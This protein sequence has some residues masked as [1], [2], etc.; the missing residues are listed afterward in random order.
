MNYKEQLKSV[1]NLEQLFDF[2]QTLLDDE[3]KYSSASNS[4]TFD[5]DNLR[6]CQ[7]ANFWLSIV[8]ERI[9]ELARNGEHIDKIIKKS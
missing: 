7:E 2:R 5:V 9:I 6:K 4:K 8:N 3:K 1:E